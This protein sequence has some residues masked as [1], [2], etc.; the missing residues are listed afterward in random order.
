MAAPLFALTK[1]KKPDFIWK[2]SHEQAFIAL[3]KTLTEPPLLSF[4]NNKDNFILDTDASDVAI[5]A[6]LLQ[7]QGGVEK[8]IAY[9]SCTLSSEQRRYCTTRKEL[10]AVVRFTRHFRYYLIGRKFTLHTDHH[11]LTW[12]MRF[13]EP[14]CQIARWLE[15]LS[16]YHMTIER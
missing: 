6:E 3:K 5:G 14:Q 7:I 13:K 2:N 1:K 8:V 15:E 11:S 9:A 16:Q 12:F 10:L 4:P